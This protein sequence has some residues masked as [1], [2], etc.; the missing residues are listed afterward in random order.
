M[1]ESE[2]SLN[3][4]ISIQTREEALIRLF[5]KSFYIDPDIETKPIP[6]HEF[7][8][9]QEYLKE[10]RRK[11]GRLKD[12]IWSDPINRSNF[13]SHMEELVDQ[14]DEQKR[15]VFEGIYINQQTLEE[16]APSIPRLDSKGGF[17]VSKQNV[18]HLA[19]KIEEI[20]R[21]GMRDYFEKL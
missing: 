3:D 15:I 5:L 14:F 4:E 9:R 21:S 19:R 20:T 12:F 2:P 16:I 13:M 1:T 18:G 17:G 10:V 7:S 6:G 8:Q 11:Y